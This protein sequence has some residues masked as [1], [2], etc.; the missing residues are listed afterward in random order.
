M[1]LSTIITLPGLALASVLAS[2]LQQDAAL[3][4]LDNVNYNIVCNR[5]NL[6][7]NDIQFCI[8]WMSNRSNGMVTVKVHSAIKMCSSGNVHIT[9]RSLNK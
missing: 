6:N 8:D 5:N 3:K 1:L 4:K 9:A 7:M 2:P